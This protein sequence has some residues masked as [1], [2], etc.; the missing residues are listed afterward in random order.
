MA[1]LIDYES[2]KRD[3][4]EFLIEIRNTKFW[5][6][7]LSEQ[8]YKKLIELDTKYKEWNKEKD[9]LLPNNLDYALNV[10][11]SLRYP[12]NQKKIKKDIDEA[13]KFL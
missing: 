12:L 3:I 8:N 6:N 7:G 5:L 2:A 1:N 10:L 11:N 4:K 13:I 9:K